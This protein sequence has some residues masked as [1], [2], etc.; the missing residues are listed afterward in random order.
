MERISFHSYAGGAMAMWQDA[1]T[2]RR[3]EAAVVGWRVPNETQR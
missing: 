3:I 1:K 2:N